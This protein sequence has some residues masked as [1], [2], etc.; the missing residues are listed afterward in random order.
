MENFVDQA[1]NH[2]IGP[3]LN[4]ILNDLDLSSDKKIIAGAMFKGCDFV[5]NDMNKTKYDKRDNK[6][7]AYKAI[8]V[9]FVNQEIRVIRYQKASTNAEYKEQY[10][11]ILQLYNWQ[12][13]SYEESQLDNV[14]K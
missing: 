1:L 8:G 2:L 14:E 11:T 3:N 12:Q 5:F 6:I 13:L 9:S 7:I 10:E 4:K